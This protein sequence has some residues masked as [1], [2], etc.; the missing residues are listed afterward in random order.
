MLQGPV[1]RRIASREVPADF[2][3]D[4][5][6]FD[7]VPPGSIGV[8]ETRLRVN[9]TKTDVKPIQRICKRGGLRR[10]PGNS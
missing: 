8:N 3:Q 9:E 5:A 6:R 1:D 4:V 2:V 10:H 7:H